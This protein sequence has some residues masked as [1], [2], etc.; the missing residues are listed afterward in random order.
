M[1]TDFMIFIRKVLAA[2]KALKPPLG[3]PLA[4]MRTSNRPIGRTWPK[5]RSTGV[6]HGV[7]VLQANRD[8]DDVSQLRELVLGQNV[9]T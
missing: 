7:T 6:L 1:S 2:L 8:P 3:W 9:L 4:A 5:P